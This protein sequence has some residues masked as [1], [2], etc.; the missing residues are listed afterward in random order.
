MC[1]VQNMAVMSCFRLPRLLPALVVHKC[2]AFEI[3]VHYSGKAFTGDAIWTIPTT[4]RVRPCLGS[5]S[6]PASCNG[7]AFFFQF[8]HEKHGL[9]GAFVSDALVG[10]SHTFCIE[11]YTMLPHY[12]NTVIFLQRCEIS[13]RYAFNQVNLE[14]QWRHVKHRAQHL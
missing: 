13:L 2:M 8:R 14:Q 6:L 10:I 11:P 9:F 3:G 4:P 7:G 1:G 5:A 12:I